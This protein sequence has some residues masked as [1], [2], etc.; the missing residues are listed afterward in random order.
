[1]ELFTVGIMYLQIIIQLIKMFIL[2][3]YFKSNI[4]SIA[5]KSMPVLYSLYCIVIWVWSL[6]KKTKQT[7]MFLYIYILMQAYGVGVRRRY[8]SRKWQEL[9]S[10]SAMLSLFFF[11]IFTV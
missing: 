6:G 4:S 7:Q 1:M 8:S 3:H 9:L 11:L 5:F 2:G 10:L